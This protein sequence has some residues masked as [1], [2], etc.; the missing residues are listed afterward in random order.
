MGPRDPQRHRRPASRV[1]ETATSRRAPEAGEEN[2]PHGRRREAEDEARERPE[3][4]APGARCRRTPCDPTRQTARK[5]GGRPSQPITIQ[6]SL[7]IKYEKK[8]NAQRVMNKRPRRSG[9][10]CCTWA[11]RWAG[12]PLL[13]D[14]R[15]RLLQGRAPDGAL[16]QVLAEHIVKFMYTKSVT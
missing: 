12:R 10:S 2:P 15:Q 14:S 1:G 4:A 16:L 11:L 13:P 9:A 3:S 5:S 7:I 6:G 8:K